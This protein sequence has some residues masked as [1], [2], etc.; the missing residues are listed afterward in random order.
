MKY[1]TIKKII[2]DIDGVLI[3]WEEIYNNTIHK[4]LDELNFSYTDELCN[5]IWNL[6][7]NYET[8][9]MYYNDKIFLD[10]INS[11]LDINLPPE[12]ISIWRK[13]IQN[14]VPKNIDIDLI[15]TLEYLSNKYELVALTNWFADDQIERLKKINILKYFKQV[16]GGEKYCKPKKEAFIQTF[17]EH[18]P[19]ECAMIGDNFN[20]DI[21]GAKNAGIKYLFWIDSFNV[22]DKVDKK[23]KGINII[24]N[25]NDLKNIL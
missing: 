18:Q 23:L 3:K 24:K 20:M 10:Y 22:K 12:Y 21:I 14:C 25:V 15:K 19:N 6:Q 13:N 5:E 7:T 9:I 1:H 16:Y 2:F 17:G 11:K 8:D 4:T